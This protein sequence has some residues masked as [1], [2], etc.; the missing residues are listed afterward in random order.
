MMD[1]LAS[2]IMDIVA[3]SVTA[4]A[5]NIQVSIS[6]DRE[7]SVLTLLI[8]DDGVGMDPDMT[9]KVQDPFFSTKTGRKVGLGIP[10]LKGTAET[11]GGTFSLASKIG[12]G[13]EICVSFDIRHPDL[14]PLGNIRD[15]VLVLVVGNPEVDFLFNLNA[16]GHEFILDTKEVKSMLDGVPINYP[17]IITFLGKYLDE[18]MGNFFEKLS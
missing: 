4:R 1:E 11:T 7:R 2:H 9:K 6:Q 15:T 12:K 8:K 13:T 5:K 16:D 17:E 10:L 18:N 3:N 14:P